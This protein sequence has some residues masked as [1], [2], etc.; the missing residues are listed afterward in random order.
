MKGHRITYSAEELAWIEAHHKA[1]RRATHATFMARFGR[2]D[3]SLSNFNALCK[4]KGWL[5]GRTGRF[6][7]GQPPPNKG[8]TMP[9]HPNSAATRFKKGQ[10]PHNT[11]YL[12]HERVSKDGYVEISIDQVNPHTGFGRRYVLKHKYLWEQKNGPLPA[13]HCLKCLDGNRLNTDPSNWEAIP[14]AMMPYLGA[15]YGL[16]Y[17]AADPESGRRLWRSPSSNT[18]RKRRCERSGPSDDRSG[19]VPRA[20]V[21]PYA[22]ERGT[23]LGMG[24]WRALAGRRS[25][26]TWPLCAR[27]TTLAP[28][29]DAR[30]GR[31]V[32]DAVGALPGAGHPARAGDMSPTRCSLFVHGVVNGGKSSN[33]VPAMSKFHRT[34]AAL[35]DELTRQGIRNADIGRLTR[36]V[37]M[38]TD[39]VAAYEADRYPV[40]SPRQPPSRCVN[41][42]CDD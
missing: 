27:E 29:P 10:L 33:G 3:L 39:L 15:R 35:F 6:S 21:P 12:G 41:G 23:G 8:K 26:A 14:R 13:D 40:Q 38:A 20:R 16:D 17:D 31:Q 2:A 25:P 24:L 11:K 32:C 7:P 42:A 30:C 18:L 19:H 36:A 4:R 28:L 34:H 9:Y 37:L 1:G 22:P 5:T